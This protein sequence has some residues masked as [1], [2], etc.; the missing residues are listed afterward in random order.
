MELKD[1]GT[2][3]G[4]YYN[5]NTGSDKGEYASFSGTFSIV[6]ESDKKSY[7]LECSDFEY[8]DNKALNKEKYI[9][10]EPYKKDEFSLFKLYGS[11]S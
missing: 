7:Y 5:L 6:R 10:K 8:S 2:F 4:G 3:T 1:D 11:L 9:Y